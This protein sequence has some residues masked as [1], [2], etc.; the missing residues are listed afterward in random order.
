MINYVYPQE[1]PSAMEPC[2]DLSISRA[3]REIPARMIMRHNDTRG[4]IG[5]GIGKNFARV[6]KAGGE[7]A[8]GYDAPGNQ[9]VRAV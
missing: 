1:F 5:N 6:D 2:G 4:A 3:G 7:C 8:H 9:A